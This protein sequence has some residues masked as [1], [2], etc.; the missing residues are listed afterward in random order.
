[1]NADQVRDSAALLDI[2]DWVRIMRE[3]PSKPLTLEISDGHLAV[4]E[5]A[6]PPWL[7][8]LMLSDLEVYATNTLARR[9]VDLSIM[10][11]A[12]TGSGDVP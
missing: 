3:G 9:G 5:V 8:K 1:M 10:P 7:L 2:L 6:M 11:D 12:N 4:R